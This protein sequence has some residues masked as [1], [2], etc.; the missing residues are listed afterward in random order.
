M[1]NNSGVIKTAFINHKNPA[2]W[3]SKYGSITFNIA[4]D[5]PLTGMNQKG[6]VV[7]DMALNN[8]DSNEY[9]FPKTKNNPFI[10]EG[11]QWI[12]YQLDNS[13]NVKEVI[14]STRKLNLIPQ[15]GFPNFLDHFFICDKEGHIAVI[16]FMRGE[17]IV[18]TGNELPVPLVTNWKYDSELYNLVKFL[19]FDNKN[20]PD[21]SK[22]PMYSDTWQDGYIDDPRSIRGT[23]LLEK[24]EKNPGKSLLND[25]FD[26]LNHMHKF[27]KKNDYNQN[28]FEVVYN[29]KSMI[30]YFNTKK[31]RKIRELKFSDF[32]FSKP[33]LG[34]IC[35]ANKNITNVKKDFLPY[36]QK[37]N[38]EQGELYMSQRINGMGIYKK[39]KLLKQIH[40]I[41]N[42]MIEY[43]NTFKFV[44]NNH[45]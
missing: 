38:R 15:M 33:S 22:A 41:G 34:L 12:Q 8:Y 35:D 29:P 43:P 32:S 25:A 42:M 3:T 31:N 1:T 2:K 27:F 36:S 26:I 16:E 13:A 23:Y 17:M 18:H 7:T 45:K 10:Q 4:K 20:K 14:D 30:L 37:L 6:L 5:F 9:P 19:K 39:P 28:N 11:S 21:L 24:Y 40:K 44:K